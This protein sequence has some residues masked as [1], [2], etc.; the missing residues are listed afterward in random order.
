VP[1]SYTYPP[2][3]GIAAQ[4]LITRPG[5]RTGDLSA[6]PESPPEGAQVRPMRSVTW[7]NSI[8]H[9]PGLRGQM[10]SVR[11]NIYSQHV[12]I[13]LHPQGELLP[14]GTVILTAEESHSE[15]TKSPGRPAGAIILMKNP[16]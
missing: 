4:S 6:N 12:V 14:T 3:A 2:V 10:Q 7:A 8:V 5:S 1:G 16:G 9:R 15:L 11:G 13:T